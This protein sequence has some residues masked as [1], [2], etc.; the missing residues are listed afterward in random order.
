MTKD[1]EI[2]RQPEAAGRVTNSAG[3]PIHGWVEFRPLAAN[4]NL[5][6]KPLLAEPR[7]RQW[8]P[9]SGLDKDGRY[10]LPIIPGPGVLL[11]HAEGDYLPSRLAREHRL[12]D[13]A[14]DDDPEL[15]DCRPHPAWPAEFQAYKLIDVAAGKDVEADL[16]VMAG[17]QRPLALE[18]PDAKPRDVTVLGLQPY[19]HPYADLGTAGEP[20]VVRGLTKE[21]NRRLYVATQDKQLAA[22]VVVAGKDAGPVNVKLQPTG[23]VKGRLL[24]KDGKPIARASFQVLFED[25]PGRPG[26]RL[27]GMGF[28]HRVPTPDEQKRA[29]KTTGFR[30]GDKM[31]FVTGPEESDDQ[32]R[33]RLDGLIAGVPFDLGVQLV[34]EPDPKGQRMIRGQVKTVRASVK[35]GETL[36]LGDVKVADP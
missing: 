24:D 28:G 23:G 17:L 27:R 32:G 33:F 7:W 20:L 12:K 36:D 8:A 34:S 19:P 26:V 10:S 35:P 25:E 14:V 6:D 11:V 3:E 18:F 4:P 31:N 30:G 9:S 5:K 22:M 16:Q 29:E 13:V 1:V 21:E 2:D 15:I